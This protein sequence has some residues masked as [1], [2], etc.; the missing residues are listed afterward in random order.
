MALINAGAQFG[1]LRYSRKHESEA[2]HAGLLLMATAGYDRVIRRWA[3]NTFA[4]F[5]DMR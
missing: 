3:E 4:R 5:P 1:I 2:D